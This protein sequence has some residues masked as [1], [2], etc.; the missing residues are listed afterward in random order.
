MPTNYPDGRDK[1][2][3]P[4]LPEEIP[5]AQTGYQPGSDQANPARNHVEHHRDLGDAVQALEEHASQTVH[6]HSGGPL[7]PR[8][9]PRLK[10]AN[11]HQ[12]ADTDNGAAAI[13]HT[14]GRGAGQAA[15]GNHTHD[16]DAADSGLLNVPFVRCTSG[17]RP[18]PAP[19]LVIYE[20]DTNRMRAWGD[21]GGGA[22]WALL[23][24]ASVPVVRLL[25][26]QPQTVG[27]PSGITLQWGTEVEDGFGFFSPSSPQSVTVGETGVYHLDVAVQWGVQF[28]PEVATVVACVNGGETPLRHSRLQ[29]P[30]LLSLLNVANVDTNRSQ[31]VSLSGN[32]RLAAGQALSVKCKYAGLTPVGTFVNTFIDLDTQVR[33]R[34]DLHY[35]GP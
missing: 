14:L 16:F 2:Y 8:K 5:L 33:S 25:Q 21:F 32:L 11:T 27:S 13:H 24:A 18:A 28:I 10:Q 1:F 12:E 30:N 9:G 6:D 20:T 29:V 35:V 7:D 34:L 17:T 22:R 3:E 4:S 23:P 26:T 15:P 31:T 19:G